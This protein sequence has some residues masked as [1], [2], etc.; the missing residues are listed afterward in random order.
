MTTKKL[1][2]LE[3]NNF[4]VLIHNLK[5]YCL[6][7]NIK[8]RHLDVYKSTKYQAIVAACC[9]YFDRMVI[10]GSEYSKKKYDFDNRIIS[11]EEFGRFTENFSKLHPDLIEKASHKFKLLLYLRNNRFCVDVLE[12]EVRTQIIAIMMPNK[13]TG[14]HNGKT[15]LNFE[16]AI[17]YQVQK[18]LT[19]GTTNIDIL[20]ELPL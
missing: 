18:Y 15:A 1:K 17:R 4:E 2:S 16:N 19:Q 14:D 13:I 12:N 10:L 6:S 7:H 20:T 9:P 11:L 8:N 3:E 5:K